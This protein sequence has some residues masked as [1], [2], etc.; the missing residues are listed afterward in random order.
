MM[1]QCTLYSS[2]SKLQALSCRPNLLQ[3][4]ISQQY[5]P[6]THPP[7]HVLVG[8]QAGHAAYCPD[9]EVRRG[10]CAQGC[11]DVHMCDGVWDAYTVRVL[12]EL[13]PQACFRCK[14]HDK[15]HLSPASQGLRQRVWGKQGTITVWKVVCFAVR[16]RQDLRA[17][18]CITLCILSHKRRSASPGTCSLVVNSGKTAIQHVCPVWA[19]DRL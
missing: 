10:L 7:P 11:V 8:A 5:D 18:K 1:M 16:A 12:F 15:M 13:R 4:Q 19:Q 14:E 9:D 17:F 6:R 3:T 2:T